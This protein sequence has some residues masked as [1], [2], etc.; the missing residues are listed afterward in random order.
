MDPRGE[1]RNAGSGVSEGVSAVPTSDTLATAA[2]W[3]AS[4]RE[5]RSG[6]RSVPVDAHTL[7]DEEL[8]ERVAIRD[9][10]AFEE[11][12]A[13]YSRAVYS[14]VARVVRDRGQSE[15]AV[16][17][18]FA[19]VWRAAGGY[20]RE[21]GPATAWLFTVARNAAIDM[22]RRQRP[23]A[24]SEP[25]ETADPAPQ[26]DAQVASELQAFRVHAAVDALPQR[27][28]EA[29]ELAFFS[30]LSHSEVAERLQLP[31]GTV[32]TRIRSGLARLAA[33]LGAEVAPG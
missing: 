6:L 33:V 26:P 1:N 32:K 25:Q 15:D 23:L 5:R 24:L 20:R 18:A 16:Q 12:Y 9:G 7:S 27:E 31:L 22:A 21:R 2:G 4:M 13:R 11:L 8:L 3:K 30:G 19:S 14:L 28:R 10:E 29:I 17:D